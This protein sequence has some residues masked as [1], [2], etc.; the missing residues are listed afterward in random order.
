MAPRWHR[1]PV[2]DVGRG[3]QTPESLGNGGGG[4]SEPWVSWEWGCWGGLTTLPPPH[5]RHRLL[6]HGSP[7]NPPGSALPLPRAPQPHRY[8][9]NMGGGHLGAWG[10]GVVMT[11]GWGSGE[12]S[13]PRGGGLGFL[14]P[15]DVGL[16]SLSPVGLGL[17]GFPD[18]LT[19]LSPHRHHPLR[20]A[21]DGA[22]SAPRRGWAPHGA[23]WGWGEL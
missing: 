22:L 16:G 18:S 4:C 11:H 19:P 23:T 15:T 14:C 13:C 3:A 10:W 21:G 8:G 5:S 17:G 2:S 12:H 1:P 20:G 6:P 9:G 7:G